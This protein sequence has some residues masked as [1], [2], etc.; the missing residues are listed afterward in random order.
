M[1]YL[2]LV[3]TKYIKKG[4]DYLM[5]LFGKKKKQNDDE[6]PVVDNGGASSSKK[7]K[8]ANR[9]KGGMAEVLN[10]SVPATVEDELKS[11]QSFIHHK[12]GEE[13]FVGMLLHVSDIG[14][15]DKKS[16]KTESKGSLIEAINSGNLKTVITPELLDNEEIV[17]IPDVKT[18]F[19]MLDF[20]LLEQSPETGETIKYDLVYV[21]VN[22]N[23]N[24]IT[25][26]PLEPAMSVTFSEISNL[27]GEQE[28]TIDDL[29]YSEDDDYD[30]FT[31]S[32][33]EE[34]E[35]VSG[36]YE[37][38]QME[39]DDSDEIPMYEDDGLGGD[40]DDIDDIDD[41]D[42]M[43]DSYDSEP[44]D[45]QY[46]Y[47]ETGGYDQYAEDGTYEP[48]EQP[49]EQE[50]EVPDDWMMD[51]VTRRFYSDDLGLEITTEPF[52]AQFM[53]NNMYIPFDENR[54]AGWL[55]EQLNEM[56]RLANI[57]MERMHK[58]NLF[59]MRERYFK[60]MSKHADRIQKDLDITDDR[61]QYG[62]IMDSLRAARDTEMSNVDAK[63]SRKKEDMELAWKRKL[64]EVGQDAARAAQH[65]YRERYGKQHDASIYH[66][67]DEIRS[68][69]EDDFHDA[70]HEVND[71]RR[72]EATKLLDLGITEVLEEVSDLYMSVLADENARY[73]ELEENMR[74]F[75]DDNRR[76]DIANTNTLAEE[77]RQ[78]N[79]AD[80][81]LAEQT[82]K[83]RNMQANFESERATLQAE[84]DKIRKDN[85]IRIQ[86]V[87]ARADEELAR[88]QKRNDELQRQL[89]AMREQNETIYKNARQE[90]AHQIEEKNDEVAALH[91]RLGE[92]ADQQKRTNRLAAYLVM[93]IT[94]CAIGIGFILGTYFRLGH[95]VK[96]QQSQMIQEYNQTQQN[97]TNNG[98]NAG[99]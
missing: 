19:N 44:S 60:L 75:I 79:Q 9:K 81:V 63:V 30:D 53:Q 33:V 64:Q 2:G 50:E 74:T 15:L 94:I 31:E 29:L 68:S 71:R 61:T 90:Y 18:V 77:L 23:T 4:K 32:L 85:K 65:Q 82:E 88:E 5:A 13:K 99:N 58:E 73:Q 92:A 80:A 28:G 27:I 25:V 84:I 46:G 24:R 41:I 6:N 98:A 97:S 11:N 38:P 8:K 1:S 55:N 69:I 43:G 10:E 48:Q 14:G 17:F 62:K 96:T 49:V 47:D 35:D 76:H 83:I 52:D 86:D 3:Y 26:T 20:S 56:S 40:E 70:V 37:E 54:P 42:D 39:A 12:D 89:D 36:G 34:S 59:L 45:D 93:A 22:T 91:E 51:V 16:R 66:L 7:S 87:Q 21:A 57:E 67:E 72:M 78:K 95:D